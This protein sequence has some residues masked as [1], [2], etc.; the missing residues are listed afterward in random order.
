[1]NTNFLKCRLWPLSRFNHLPQWANVSEVTPK[2][3]KHINSLPQSR[4]NILTNN[5]FDWQDFYSAGH[6]FLLNQSSF[7][8]ER[9]GSK[10]LMN[11][12]VLSSNLSKVNWFSFKKLKL[13]IL[14]SFLANIFIRLRS[15]RTLVQSQFFQMF[16]FSGI[17][18]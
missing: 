15:E 5:Q 9:V 17:G 10:L 3:E 4:N 1:M 6:W 2:L 7:S 12:K 14:H 16:F 11:L 13:M 8:N 18:R